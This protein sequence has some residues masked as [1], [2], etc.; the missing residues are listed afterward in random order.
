MYE[1]LI[2]KLHKFMQDGDPCCS[3]PFKIA[4]PCKDDA[5]MMVVCGVGDCIILQA[6]DALSEHAHGKWVKRVGENGVT[7]A[8]VCSECGFEDNRYELFDFC[9]KCGASMVGGDF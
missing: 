9:P 7:S 3:C 2:G 8:C 5:V 4:K 6:I 1:E